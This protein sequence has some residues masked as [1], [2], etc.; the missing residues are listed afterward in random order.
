MWPKSPVLLALVLV[1]LAVGTGC[2]SEQRNTTDAAP[3]IDAQNSTTDAAVDG[4]VDASQGSTRLRNPVS[5]ADNELADQ[6]AAI[7]GAG[8]SK[9]C[10]RC[11][12]ISRSRLR[13]WRSLSAAAAS[14]CLVDDVI[15]SQSQALAIV[16]CLRADPT[17]AT[18]SFRPDKLGIYATAAHLPWFATL[19]ATAF[20][21]DHAQAL[22]AFQEHV[23]MPRGEIGRLTQPEFD[24]L[25]EWFAR[26]LP[27]LD[28]VIAADP[29]VTQCTTAVSPDVTSHV[30]TM[31]TQGWRAANID[32][33]IRMFG[34]GPGQVGRDCLTGYTD[35][36]SVKWSAGWR[37]PMPQA[38]MRMLR[39]NTY[40]SSYWTR[41]SA[42]GR[43]VAHGGSS[44]TSGVYRSTVID[45]VWGREIHAA[46][47]YD[48]GFFPDNTGF[49]LQGSSARFCRQNLL[50]TLPKRIEFTEPQCSANNA[51]GLYQH[52]GAA[53]GGDYWTVD[54]QFESD[55]GGHTVTLSDPDAN[56]GSTAAIDMVPMIYN[57]SQYEPRAAIHKPLPQEGDVVMSP[58]AKLLISRVGG[59][60]PQ[61]GY[62]LRKVV[63]LPAG[64]TYTV[65]LPEI[66]RYCLRGGK[67]GISFDDRWMTFHHYVEAN[68]WDKLGY[69]SVS[70]PEFVALRQRGASN[71]YLVD[72]QQG[73]QIQVT[74]MH[75]GQYAL[76]PHFR[77]DGWIY[78]LV[79]DSVRDREYIVA[80]DAALLLERN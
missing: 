41:S 61:A 51:V 19:F 79:R 6:A 3:S 63:A 52:L 33:G 48:P 66:A 57:G 24:V 70:D 29:P 23:A 13:S 9:N 45:L 20:P 2:S 18:S 25:A 5:L 50:L 49:A 62:V 42:D 73:T 8:E 35:T 27:A 58:T 36:S 12:A 40:A 46:A 31:R 60:G 69:S 30:I 75:P 78:F 26:G 71:I 64:N 21:Q 43:F 15:T 68:D 32:A 54:G 17:Q 4:P 47:L 56:F 44:S 37:R 16:D 59:G 11:H 77:S 65:D 10:D 38:A 39:E 14:T 80:S 22:A 67:P 1:A 34:C 74:A 53:R 55:D 28:K 7:L 76:F 72:L